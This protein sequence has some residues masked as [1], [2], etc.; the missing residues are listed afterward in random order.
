MLQNCVTIC[1]EDVTYF[2]S[3]HQKG[4]VYENVLSE[5]VLSDV[6][7]QGSASINRVYVVYLTGKHLFLWSRMIN[8]ELILKATVSVSRTRVFILK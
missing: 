8:T 5:Y 7:I 1:N 6:R 4:T 3:S 2:W